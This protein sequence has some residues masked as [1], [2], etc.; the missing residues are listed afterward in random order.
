MKY[1]DAKGDTLVGF[2]E[3]RNSLIADLAQCEVLIPEVGHRFR[4]LRALING[5]DCRRR[6]P[7]I[8]VARGDD[9]VALEGWLVKRARVSGRDVDLDGATKNYRE[10][11]MEKIF[12]NLFRRLTHL[13][14]T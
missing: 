4:D 13:H 7:Q 6:L 14:L 12:F 10:K 11:K 2:R 5:L 9:A 8:E 3:K 1:V